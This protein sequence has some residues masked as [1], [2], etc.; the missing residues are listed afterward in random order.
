V[1]VKR[2]PLPLAAAVASCAAIGSVLLARSTWGVSSRLGPATVVAFIV[3]FVAAITLL[4]VAIAACQ[5]VVDE[6]DA[7]D[8]LRVRKHG[9]VARGV[10]AMFRRA[11]ALSARASRAGLRWLSSTVAASRREVTRDALGQWTRAAAA[12]LSGVAPA[13]VPPPS[14]AGRLARRDDA[15][16]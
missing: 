5:S 15:E 3:L 12:G 14:G 16:R 10:K 1:V 6:M 11:F 13:G 9:V 8:P 7:S 2:V 4:A